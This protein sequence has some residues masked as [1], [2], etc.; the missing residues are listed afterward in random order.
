M[1]MRMTSKEIRGS[2]G[3]K[4]LQ[5]VLPSLLW[6]IQLSLGRGDNF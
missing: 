5:V 1:L 6:I 2:L 4:A 3:W